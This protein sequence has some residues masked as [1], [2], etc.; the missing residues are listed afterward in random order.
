M[1]K[2]LSIIG[3]DPG[4]TSAYAVLD[5]EGNPLQ[6]YSSKELPLSQII[7]Q[8]IEISQPLVAATD[9][10][11][12]P[13]LVQDFSA[14]LGTLLIAPEQDLKKQEKR[15]LI[16]PRKITD[17]HQNTHQLDSLAAALFAYKKLKPTLIKI[18][19]FIKK[20]DLEELK[21]PFTKLI[22]KENL[23]FELAKKILTQS[24]D[25]NKIIKQV[26][27]ENK[28]NKENRITKNDFLKL[29]EKLDKIKAE[30]CHLENKIHGLNQTNFHLRQ[31][32]LFLA[33][34]LNKTDQR[35]GI[36]LEFKEKRIKDLSQELN[37]KE[38]ENELLLK[39]I[40]ELKELPFHLENKIIIKKVKDLGANFK[41]KD[42]ALKEGDYLFVENPAILSPN[43]Q[44]ELKEKGINLFSKI[45]RKG[46]FVLD[47][48]LDKED[49]IIVDK[50]VVE[51]AVT[52]RD[53]L[54]EVIEEYKNS[55]KTD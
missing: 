11:K 18:N 33:K 4:T 27:K 13:A 24:K 25:E 20:N 8:I 48:F 38:K 29:F 23:N 50:K 37:K 32:N 5:L 9:K 21:N 30:R 28:E 49:F 15:D 41:K 26:L 36:L 6:I 14:K 55:R 46:F 19:D 43:V 44:E 16:A 39:E 7:S 42:F 40:E 12:I 2:P 51:K 17:A 45:K 52:Q 54:N 22:L 34:K 3:L 47:E 35:I 10:E 1:S 53:I 31:T